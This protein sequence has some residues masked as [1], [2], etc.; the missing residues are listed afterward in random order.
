MTLNVL[1]A[2]WRTALPVA[3]AGLLA[4]AGCP[5][6]EASVE[7][8]GPPA[9][10]VPRLSEDDREARSLAS[11]MASGRLVYEPVPAFEGTPVLKGLMAGG[12]KPTEDLQASFTP[13][14]TVRVGSLQVALYQVYYTSHSWR[15][16]PV[17]IFGYYGH[18]VK[19]G[20]RQPA[21][22][23][24][25]GGGGYATLDRVQEAALHGYAALCIDLPGKGLQRERRSRSTGPDMTVEQIFNTRPDVTDSYIYHAVLSQMR[26]IS[27]LCN[28]PEVD[29]NRIGLLGVSWGGATGL[30]TTSLDTRV[31]AFVD[32][33]G[34][35][36]LWGGSTWHAYFERLAKGE[37]QRWEDNYDASR[38]VGDIRVPVLGVTGT[39][40]N[41]Y[42]LDR[43]VRTLSHIQPTPDLLLRPNLDHK[44]DEVAKH[45]LYEWLDVQLKGTVRRP[46]TLQ[47]FR[48]Q[49]TPTGLRL[50]VYPGGQA[51]V[52]RV[53][54]CY[55]ETG[56]QG[57][58][59][60]NRTWRTVLCIP[61]TQRSWWSGEIVPP[62]QVTYAFAT[63]YFGNGSVLSTPVH[64]VSRLT[65][66][67]RVY[68]VDLPLMVNSPMRI[69]ARLFAQLAG[70]SFIDGPEAGK[71]TLERSG[72][73]AV[74][75]ARRLG[76]LRFVKVRE[77]TEDLGG[78]VSWDPSGKTGIEF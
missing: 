62:T 64:S 17:R 73:Q 16:K 60:T 27:L 25:H 35:G 28:R 45:A 51:D 37:Y 61:D 20:K 68:P 33:Y 10:P 65:F 63:V 3:L 77:A 58:G 46:P 24:V 53:E 8:V 32:L 14:P 29:A 43:F 39:N 9:P 49:A 42:Y 40:D 72:K 7:P 41:C 55:G 48:S 15:G 38:Y 50:F 6:P 12:W 30:I 59:W 5:A 36:Y 54:V 67:G 13:L 76:D 23:L 21:L 19:P 4:L 11:Q 47:G 34:S 52:S 1:F 56:S 31:R 2:R 18:P 26:G 71:V 44:I 75:E 70:A 69:E 57:I 22:L 74:L 66:G 78:K